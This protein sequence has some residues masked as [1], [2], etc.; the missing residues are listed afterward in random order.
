MRD[1]CIIH[2]TDY[3]ASLFLSLLERAV[4]IYRVLERVV[5]GTGFGN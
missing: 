2:D 3:F 1:T 5:I 4:L